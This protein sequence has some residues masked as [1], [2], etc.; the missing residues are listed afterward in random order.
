MVSPLIDIFFALTFATATIPHPSCDH[1]SSLELQ[2]YIGLLFVL[3]TFA[4]YAPTHSSSVAAA[5][6]FVICTTYYTCTLVHLIRT[7]LLCLSCRPRVEHQHGRTPKSQRP[8]KRTRLD[9]GLG[10]AHAQMIRFGELEVVHLDE[11]QNCLLHRSQLQQRHF[12]VLTEN[13]KKR[14]RKVR[15]GFGNSS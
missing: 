5:C 1:H 9:V 4:S 3:L 6:H 2:Q 15:L 13:A 7:R 12:A 11:G 10:E 8:L 14:S